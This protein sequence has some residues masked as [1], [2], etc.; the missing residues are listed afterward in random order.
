MLF[1]CTHH[2]LTDGPTMDFILKDMVI[3]KTG[4]EISK[5]SGQ[6]FLCKMGYS[7][8]IQ[9]SGIEFKIFYLKFKKKNHKQYFVAFEPVTP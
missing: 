6:T 7:F 2:Y 4:G 5:T 8:F 1:C 9:V 3:L